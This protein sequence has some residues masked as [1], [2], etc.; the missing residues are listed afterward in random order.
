[1]NEILINIALCFMGFLIL[2]IWG[3]LLLEMIRGE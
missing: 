2:V 3:L 1:M